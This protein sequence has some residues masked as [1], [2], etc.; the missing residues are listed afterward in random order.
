MPALPP[1]SSTD[2]IG[3]TSENP[4]IIYKNNNV[5]YA[6]AS[7]EAMSN[8]EGLEVEINKKDKNNINI[9]YKCD[10]PPTIAIYV[11]EKIDESD[12]ILLFRES[13]TNPEDVI[14]LNNVL[15]NWIRVV[16]ETTDINIVL[17]IKCSK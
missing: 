11:K 4:Y 17:K 12:E 10:A 14:I 1:S 3:D 9:A 6:V 15:F 16:V 8:H 13:M 7:I 5:V 2:T